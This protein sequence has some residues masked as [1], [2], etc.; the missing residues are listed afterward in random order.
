[1]NVNKARVAV[2]ATLVTVATIGL[3]SITSK[4]EASSKAQQRSKV[5][6]VYLQLKSSKGQSN[7]ESEVALQ[8]FWDSVNTYA[9][10]NPSILNPS[11]RDCNTAIKLLTQYERLAQKLDRRIS[12]R[13]IRQL[14]EKRNNGTITDNDLPGVLHRQFPGIFRGKSLNQIRAICNRPVPTNY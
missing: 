6:D 13:R 3:E 9:K 2:I 10:L 7:L 14:D 4:V 1:M 5:V 11:R 12:D 8:A